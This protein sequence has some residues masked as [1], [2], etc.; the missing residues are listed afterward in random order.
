MSSKRS[1][2]G[3]P[4]DRI[5]NKRRLSS[6][7]EGEVDNEDDLENGA[8]RVDDRANEPEETTGVDLR[9]P[10]DSSGRGSSTAGH[11]VQHILNK[12]PDFLPA[13]PL[14]PEELRKTATTQVKSKVPFPFKTKSRS[15]DEENGI[16]TYR[17][18][19]DDRRGYD[20]DRQYD[21]WS[22]GKQR[23]YSSHERSAFT[24]SKC[25]GIS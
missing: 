4:S 9:N 12:K 6:P 25:H 1:A 11:R 15:N 20:R 23:D 13:R 2:S 24:L 7:E 21:S 18:D 22:R 5:K 10:I 19:M 8:F 17:P 16:N 3:S 14:T